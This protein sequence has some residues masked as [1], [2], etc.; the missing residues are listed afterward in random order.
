MAVGTRKFTYG[1]MAT[2]VSLFGEYVRGSRYSYTYA[3]DL[4]NDGSGLNDLIFIPTDS[5]IESMKFSGDAAAQAAQKSGLKNYITNDKYLNGNRG[6]IAE[7]YATLAPWYSNWDLRILQ[8]FRLKNKNVIQFSADILNVGNLL[9]KN[10]GVRQWAGETGLA[11][12]VAVGVDAKGVPTYT[13]D[14]TQKSAIQN[15][16]D[17]LSRW[18]MQFGLRYSF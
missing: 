1:N 12:P 7:K 9:S 11:Q 6:K 3:G 14:T 8:D 15:R 10:W 18:R 17:I 16:F 2:T 4:N 13:F 5:Q